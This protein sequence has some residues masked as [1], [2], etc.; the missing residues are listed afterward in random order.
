MPGFSVL[1]N[2][3]LTSIKSSHLPLALGI[4]DVGGDGRYKRPAVASSLQTRTSVGRKDASP[5]F[6]NP[7]SVSARQSRQENLSLVK[8]LWFSVISICSF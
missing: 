4:V 5:C 7:C 8:D 1:A 2:C 6:F 3:C